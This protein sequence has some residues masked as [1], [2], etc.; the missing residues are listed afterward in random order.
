MWVRFDNFVHSGKCLGENS[1][2]RTGRCH[3]SLHSWDKIYWKGYF[4]FDVTHSCNVFF[5][6][7]QMKHFIIIRI[8]IYKQPV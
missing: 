7:L 6:E 1:F 2:T 8:S 3:E 5:A 4:T